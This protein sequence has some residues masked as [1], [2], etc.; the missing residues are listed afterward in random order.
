M[1]IS[2]LSN[3]KNV[4]LQN[5][6][7][8]N[9]FLFKLDVTRLTLPLSQEPS[10]GIAAQIIYAAASVGGKVCE[11]RSSAITA[12]AEIAIFGNVVPGGQ[13]AYTAPVGV[14]G[15][16]NNLAR[17][18]VVEG[19]GGVRSEMCHNCELLM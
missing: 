6:K 11:Q 10:A 13:A 4:P 18:G 12:V 1:P 7:G 9:F 5:R 2:L 16:A 14:G 15:C 19:M 3:G 8:T 17:V